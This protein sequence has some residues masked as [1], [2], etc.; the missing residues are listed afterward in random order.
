MNLNSLTPRQQKVV[1]FMVFSCLLLLYLTQLT[2][3]GL[4]YD[5]G[6]EYLYSKFMSGSLPDN[7][8]A[9]A[10]GTNSMYDRVVM[11]F[12]P[13]LYNL[14]MYVWLTFFDS[15]LTFRLPGVIVTFIGAIGFY[16]SLK[17][18]S[19][20]YYCALIGTTGYLLLPCVMFYG[21]EC[22]E[23]NL[24]LCFVVW[25]Q[26][27]FFKS[28]R[29]NG[30]NTN[31]NNTIFFL[32]FACLAAY[33]QYG[34]IL[35]M[36][37]LYIIQLLSYI[38]RRDKKMVRFSLISVVVALVLF[39]LPLL[40]FFLLP[41]MEN[42]ES[43]SVSHAPVFINNVFYSLLY[44]LAT[45]S[46]FMFHAL[47][48]RIMAIPI[49]VFGIMSAI[50]LFYKNKKLSAL[51]AFSV[52]NYLLYFILVAH[53]FYAYN[54]WNESYGCGNLG[55]RYTLYLV[56]LV[57][58]T[59]FY[60]VYLFYRNTVSQ[61]KCISVK[62]VL[63]FGIVALYLAALI[64]TPGVREKDAGER[65]AFEAWYNAGGY[66]HYTLVEN[67]QNPAFQFYY[68]H[69]DKYNPTEGSKVVGEGYWSRKATTEEVY[70][71][72]GK[73]GTFSKDTVIIVSSSRYA[74][75]DK[76]KHHDEAMQKAGYIPEF[77]LDRR[78]S[79]INKTS[80]IRYTK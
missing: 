67:F 19:S 18:I 48:S 63:F 27:Y 47:L 60:G 61:G 78:D 10:E 34:A 59:F 40:I 13:P 20:D 38:K 31:R 14:L 44:G 71:H 21:L 26:Y 9:N 62:K 25:G 5:E 12:Q 17:T 28:L 23:Y 50:A 69:S 22:A 29:D 1:L 80:V 74:N 42:Q 11:T 16:K 35:I 2:H 79:I 3:V 72:L 41:Q 15:E 45:L 6:I 46:E 68:M 39:G 37:T 52:V 75:N 32:V 57:F 55:G 53:S 54:N 4:W 43:L 30:Y 77:I 49:S 8:V 33:T 70:S 64:H 51:W 66:N 56:P 65:D 7:V 24:M 76:L 36:G 58:L 73:M